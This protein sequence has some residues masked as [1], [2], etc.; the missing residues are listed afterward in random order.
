MSVVSIPSSTLLPSPTLYMWSP[1]HLAID[2]AASL[3]RTQ[4]R[5][6]RRAEVMVGGMG[7]GRVG[8]TGP[9]TPEHGSNQKNNLISAP[10]V[11]KCRICRCVRCVIQARHVVNRGAACISPPITA[12][13]P[14]TEPSSGNRPCEGRETSGQHRHYQLFTSPRGRRWADGGAARPD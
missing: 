13:R 11:M 4:P 10:L 9:L 8:E 14:D 5:G 6:R 7:E 12:A 2:H 1:G 3:R